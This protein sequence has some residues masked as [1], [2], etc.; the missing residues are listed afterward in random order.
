V[1]DAERVRRTASKAVVGGFR[2]PE[3]PLASW[4]GGVRVAAP[5]EKWPLGLE[6]PM[7]AIA[8]FNLDEPPFLP[9]ALK[10]L[11]LITI[12]A[13]RGG[14][15]VLGR[16]NGEGWVLRAYESL[17]ML[18]E[19]DPPRDVGHTRPFPIQWELVVDD[20]DEGTKLGGRPNLVQGDITIPGE[21]VIQLGVEEKS[22]VA[23]GD[24][25]YI[26]RDGDSWS[27]EVQFY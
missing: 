7:V 11:S 6:L 18:V 8:Q 24:N 20:Y 2:P 25:A 14:V 23:L 1:P 13:D 3:D 16:S 12:F 15:P 22:H 10:D 5:G 21:F 17:D 26:C 27:M 19:I 9:D 4:S